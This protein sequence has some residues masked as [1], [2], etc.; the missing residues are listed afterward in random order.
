[1]D[2]PFHDFDGVDEAWIRR[3]K[4]KARELRK[5]RWWRH[6]LA[7]GLCY[8]CGRKSALAELTMDHVVPLALGGGSDKNNLVPCCK[9]CNNA[10]RNILPQDWKTTFDI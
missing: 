9:A 8:Y 1:M 2:K 5:T 7:Q 6:K 10:K 3:E 4:T